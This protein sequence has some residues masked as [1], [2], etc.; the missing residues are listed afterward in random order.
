MIARWQVAVNDV[1][2]MV[3]TSAFRAALLGTMAAAGALTITTT[4]TPPID[5]RAASSVPSLAALRVLL[6][7]I[8]PWMVARQLSLERGDRLVELI[9]NASMRPADMLE[10]KMLAAAAWA[11]IVVIMCAPPLAVA[12]SSSQVASP[13]LAVPALGILATALL[14]IVLSTHL[15]VMSSARLRPWAL[16]TAASLAALFA[17]QLVERFAGA[18]ASLLVALVALVALT[19]WLRIRANAGL[20]SYAAT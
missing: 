7:L 4:V 19:A 17:L 9:A 6:A 13:T 3:R 18:V 8:I 5:M 14:A 10:G 2:F 20:R 1:R 16:A 12:W 15:C 11:G